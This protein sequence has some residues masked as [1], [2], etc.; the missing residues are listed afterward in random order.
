MNQNHRQTRKRLFSLMLSAIMA[1][2]CVVPA[3][4][5]KPIGNGITP[6]YDE[7]YYATLDYYGNLTDGSVVKSYT[8]NGASS[9]T[10]YGTYENIINLT[11]G[12]APS[13]ADGAATFHFDQENAPTHFYFEG[14]T[15]APFE[16]LPWTISITYTLNGVPTKAEDLAGKTGVVEIIV[17]AVPN[18]NASEYA[19]NNYTLEATAMFNQDD[20]LSLEAPGAQVQL[21]GNLRVVLFAALPGETQ[22]FVIRVGSDSFSFD[23]LTFLLTPAT[24][25]QLEEISK[26]SQRKDELEE[27]Y[28]KLS[29]SLDELLNSFSSLG[30]SLRETADGLDE[31]NEARETISN[32]KDQIYADGD[33]V[34]DDLK[35]LNGSMNKLPGHLENADGAVTDVTDSLNDVSDAAVRLQGNLKDLDSC[36]KRLQTDLDN[37][38]KNNGDLDSN[39][40]AL[41][42]DLAQLK[43]LLDKTK[44]NIK[45]LNIKIKGGILQE[46]LP[47]TPGNIDSNITIQGMTPSEVKTALKKAAPVQKAWMTVAKDGNTVKETIPYSDY[48]KGVLLASGK[49]ST[50]EEAENT[51]KQMGTLVSTI[52]GKIAAAMKTGMTQEQAAAAVLGQIAQTPGGATTVASYKQAKLLEQIYQVLCGDTTAPMN[53]VQFFAAMLMLDEVNKLSPAD[54]Q[55]PEKIHAILAN[56]DTFLQTSTKLVKALDAVNKEYDTEAI[57]GLLEKLSVLLDHM[58]NKNGLTGNLQKLLE[59]VNHTLGNLDDTADVGRDI[60]KRLDSILDKLDDLNDTINDQVPGLRDT[61]HD[62]KTLVK[63]MVITVD[64]THTFLTSFRA[65]AQNSGTKLDAGT[66]KSLE[67]LAT[68]LRRTA[69]STDA[70]SG[71]K[72]AKDAVTGIVEDTWNEYTGD[73]NNILLMDPTAKAQSLTSQQNPAPVSVQV[74]IRTQEIK[75]DETASQKAAQLQ[76]APLTF[77]DRVGQMFRDFWNAVTGIFG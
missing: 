75:V 64:D 27:D 58:G 66:K 25:G 29:G 39:L 18:E 36:L 41:G 17:D 43:E 6:T 21:I 33:K 73:L 46:I 67:N 47:D 62:T 65:L 52:D 12:T 22:Q 26:L 76:D 49:A 1:V 63:D 24:L 35:N 51:V 55:N 38:K 32:G 45:D 8:L 14:K 11:D 20:I 68:T 30:G 2:V 70:V 9:L 3:A 57:T 48:L 72:T 34:L 54:Q 37:I 19:R 71:V 61:I 7:A 28:H 15:T 31:L 59:T 44:T 5:A 50:L 42:K 56:K 74:L 23:G 10:D 4:A 16:V 53:R 40:D 77:W 60:L 69:R 13:V